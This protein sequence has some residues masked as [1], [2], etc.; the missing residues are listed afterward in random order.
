MLSSWRP[1]RYVRDRTEQ[2]HQSLRDKYHILAE[3][4]DI[5]SPIEHFEVRVP[6]HLCFPF[7]QLI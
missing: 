4:E 7:S 6:E 2:E 1:P 3:G 5:P